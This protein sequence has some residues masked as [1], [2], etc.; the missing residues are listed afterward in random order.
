MR[1]RAPARSQRRAHAS[2]SWPRSARTFA[3]GLL[4]A[5]A[6][7][8]I[9]PIIGARPGS[10][11]VVPA[12]AFVTP[13]SV[14]SWRPRSLGMRWGTRCAGSAAGDVQSVEAA[15][16]GAEGFWD[17][18]YGKYQK[19]VSIL[20]GSATVDSAALQLGKPFRGRR[21]R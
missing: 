9:A 12:V 20:T 18:P 15:A 21:R 10:C 4:A 1:P 19:T 8:L 2:G 11:R 17:S 7:A 3:A 14:R 16:T 13:A 6:V 5:G